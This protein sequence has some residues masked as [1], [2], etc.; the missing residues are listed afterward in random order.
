MDGDDGRF[1]SAMRGHW[2]IILTYCRVLSC[3]STAITLRV[4]RVHI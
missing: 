3:V 4:C 1:G 2:A